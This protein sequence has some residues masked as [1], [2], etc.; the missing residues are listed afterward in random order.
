MLDNGATYRF[1]LRDDVAFQH[2][3][4]FTPTRKLN[5]DDVVFT[6]QR[7]FNRHHPRI[8]STGNFPISTACSLPTP[9]KRAQTDNRTVEFSRDAPGCLFP[10][11]I[12][13]PTCVRH[14]R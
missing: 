14:V 7:I 6:F 13:R 4:W 10:S 8:T 5:A 2:T 12:W 9:L 11:G 3:P 1:R